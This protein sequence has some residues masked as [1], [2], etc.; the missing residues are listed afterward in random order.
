[1][2]NEKTLELN[3]LKAAFEEYDASIGE[4]AKTNSYN[5]LDDQPTI[6]TTV[7]ELSDASN[8]ALAA[9]VPTDL[10]DLT[11]TGQDPYA[12]E[13]YVD[14]NGGKIDIIKK[15][16]WAE[17]IDPSDK[18]VNIT[19]PTQLSD[20]SDGA[21]VAHTSDIPT[22]VSD[23][24][25]DSGYQTAAEVSSAIGTALASVYTYK[26]SVANQAALP[27]SGQKTGDVY[28][29]QD[30]GMNYA[31]SGSAWDP[32]GATFN[33]TYATNSEAIAIVDEVIASRS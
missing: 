11:N 28:D 25:N 27:S 33:I 2:A 1:M 31:W 13:G 20:L 12:T 17:T 15:N 21:N 8:Y 4:A 14:Q 10:S 18:S 3:A 30:T 19:V 32:L 26:G 16:G 23:L 29:T 7:A 6:P 22:A 9:D 24:T 5:D